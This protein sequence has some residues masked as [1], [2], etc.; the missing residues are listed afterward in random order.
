MKQ[1]PGFTLI[2]LLVVLAL[3]GLLSSL[4]LP[5]FQGMQQRSQRVMAKV[6][7]LKAAQW[8]ERSA[9]IQGSYPSSLPD[10]VWQV[11]PMRYRLELS[12]QS[13]AFLL[14]AVPMGSQAAD[15]CATLTLNQTGE[16]GVLGG[17][18]SASVCWDR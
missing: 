7:L 17:S 18:L 10:A 3:M 15:P 8:L 2:E 4:A 14:K 11:E 12:G 16:R 13:N 9:S 6:A 5:S 1:C